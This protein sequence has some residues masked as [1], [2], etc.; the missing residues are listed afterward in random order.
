MPPAG[1]SAER[2]VRARGLQQRGCEMII[3]APFRENNPRL[4]AIGLI[5]AMGLLILLVALWRVQVMHGVHYDN[6]QDAQSL[7]RI[8][9]PAAR[10]EIVDRNGVVLANNRPSYD[11]AI[12]LDQ[13][14]R[15]P[16][17]TDVVRVAQANLGALSA[18]LGL[19]VALGDRDV[20]IHYQRRRPLPLPVWRDLRPETVAAFAERA[21]NLPGADLIVMP[22]RQYPL[23][24]LAAHLLGYVGK[25][26]PD[27]DEEE[28]EKFYYY[29]P[30]SVGKQGVE[31]ACDEYLRGSPGGRT[32]RVNP[33]GRIADDLGEKQAER[34]GRVTLTI[35]ARLQR[36]VEDAL[37]RAPI[38][39]GKELRGAAVLL[40]ARTGEVLAMASAPGFD[41]NLFN[42]GTPA[43]VIQALLNNPSSPMLNRAI[44]A[45]YAPGSTFKT[46]TLLAGLESGAISPRDTVVCSGSMQ[47]GNW[48]RAFNCWNHEGHGR[49]DAYTAIRQSCDVWFYTEGMKTG[50]GAI[51]RA[52]AELGLGQPT[53]FDVGREETGFVPGPAWKR[54][55]YGERWWDGDTAQLSIGQ[56]Y[57]LVTPLQMAC[58]AATFGNGGTCWKPYVVKRIE[59]PDGPVVHE[60][61]PEVRARLSATP[62]QIEIIRHAM[63]GAVQEIDGTAHRAAAKG[64]RI[65]GKTGTAEYD[66]SK[67]RF[68]RAWFMGFAPYDP[69]PNQPQVALSVL[70]E[71]AD[72]G[73]HSAAPVAGDIFARMFGKN[74]EGTVAAGAAYAD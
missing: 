6:K 55:Q 36:I 70:I 37:A 7:R 2:R 17:K 58:V 50:V 12:Y 16:K 41:P 74:R 73:G 56:S 60:G 11:I 42:P 57:L 10:G 66:T 24:S 64:L 62:Q 49:I 63:L 32:I 14:G 33:A 25:A 18:A 31:K 68:K 21:S 15:L 69:S 30:D 61:A 5:V 26:Q 67:G 28:L 20:R 8:R 22:V 53:G 38:A 35:D 59:T 44:G 46:I 40:D 27:D 47:I 43:P 9:I 52:A 54:L 1:A 29:Q 13:L 39:A 48:H 65:A 51:G 23:G 4:R 72:S 3:S 19:P 45:R 34:G 71:D